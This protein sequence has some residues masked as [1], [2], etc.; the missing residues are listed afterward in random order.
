MPEETIKE[1]M[2]VRGNDQITSGNVLVW[3][4]RVNAQ[5]AQAAVM[6]TITESKEFDKIKVSIPVWTSNPRMSI[7]HNT[8]SQP[9]CRYCGSTHPPRQ[10]PAYSKVCTECSKVG[11]FCRICSSKKTRAVNEIEQETIQENIGKILKW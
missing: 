1:L 10:C 4:K 3:M 11:H 7:K 5:R 9:T 2:T 8:L 6:S